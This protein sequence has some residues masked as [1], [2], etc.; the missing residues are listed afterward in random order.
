V[1]DVAVDVRVGS[2][3]FGRWVGVTLS[4]HNHHQLYVPPGF[5]HGFC[6][7]SDH[8]AVAYKCTEVYHP[9][10][11]LVVAFDDPDI[12]IRWPVERPQLSARDTKR[13]ALSLRSMSAGCPSIVRPDDRLDLRRERAS[14]SSCLY[15]SLYCW[16]RTGRI[17]CGRN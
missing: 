15:L 6:V 3:T 11:E 8:A 14:V 4:A 13:C 2:P 9:E 16:L 1:F 17:T 10:C 12:G 7:T 5:A